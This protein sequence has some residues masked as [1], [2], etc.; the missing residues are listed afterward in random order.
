MLDHGRLVI[1]RIS[2]WLPYEAVIED[3]EGVALGTV[4]D[5][6]AHDLKLIG[7]PTRRFVVA[8][9]EGREVLAVTDPRNFGV[10]TIE[11]RDAGDARLAVV[12]RR[13]GLASHHFTVKLETG[14]AWLVNGRDFDQEFSVEADE[15]PLAHISRRMVG[16]QGAAG[17]PRHTVTHTEDATLADR[18]VVIGLVIAIDQFIAKAD[19]LTR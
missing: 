18:L 5:P 19:P 4:T 7:G 12:T 10:D 13:T 9:T 14:E 8:D 1:R 11:I 16:W 15:V 2:R 17:R 6:V 3:A